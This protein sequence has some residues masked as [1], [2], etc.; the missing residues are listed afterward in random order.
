MITI[1]NLCLTT[2]NEL[3]IM[4]IIPKKVFKLLNL[5]LFFLSHCLTD[6]SDGQAHYL[7][8]QL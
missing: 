6:T 4:V 2:K 3:V 1:Q 5:F 8:Q 7:L